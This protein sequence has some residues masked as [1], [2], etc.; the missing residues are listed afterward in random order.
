MGSLRDLRR[1][2]IVETRGSVE[3]NSHFFC[4]STS[5]ISEVEGAIVGEIYYA[6]D[7]SQLYIYTGLEKGWALVVSAIQTFITQIRNQMRRLRCE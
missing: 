7:T 6:Q 3:P 5:S 2:D 4:G 1:K